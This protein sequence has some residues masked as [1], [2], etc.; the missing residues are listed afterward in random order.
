MSVIAG[1]VRD[2]SLFESVK[3]E[4]DY[5]MEML[6]KRGRAFMEGCQ[7]RKALRH[8]RMMPVSL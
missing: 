4:R 7:S 1:I 3:N 8:V 5:Y 6:A 2:D